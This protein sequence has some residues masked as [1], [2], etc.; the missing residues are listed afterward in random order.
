VPV[1]YANHHGG[2]TT[3]HQRS[4]PD[5]TNNEDNQQ[6]QQHRQ[7]QD[8]PRPRLAPTDAPSLF[9]RRKGSAA[10]PTSHPQKR[11]VVQTPNPPQYIMG[12]K[13]KQRSNLKTPGLRTRAVLQ[14][15]DKV[16]PHRRMQR[17]RT[18]EAIRRM[19]PICAAAAAAASHQR[20][21]LALDCI[22]GPAT[23]THWPPKALHTNLQ[24]RPAPGNEGGRA[25]ATMRRA[26]TRT[27]EHICPDH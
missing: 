10:S 14:V 18:S 1:T 9:L 3:N 2:P 17:P 27:A 15:Q 11:N 7:Q 12:R 19:R 6:K 4:R 5:N 16:G 23:G 25:R 21:A 13:R 22:E 8:Q 24:P 26:H 20:Q